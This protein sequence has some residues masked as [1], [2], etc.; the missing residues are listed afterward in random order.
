MRTAGIFLGKSHGGGIVHGT[1][2]RGILDEG[3]K[4]GAVAPCRDIAQVGPHPIADTD[5]MTRGAYF[6]E[7]CLARLGAHGKPGITPEIG[8]GRPYLIA[9]LW[10]QRTNRHDQ[11]IEI[12]KRRIALPL[13]GRIVAKDDLISMLAQDLASLSKL[14]IDR[15]DILGLAGDES[16]ARARL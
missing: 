12:A 14:V 10:I 3:L 5:R 6:L 1:E 11:P 9:P 15:A 13:A 4:P 2:F 16:P 7:E 8:R